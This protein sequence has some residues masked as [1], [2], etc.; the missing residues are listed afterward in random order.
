MQ[1]S[2]GG[3]SAQGD[4]AKDRR[5]QCEEK[6][7]HSHGNTEAHIPRRVPVDG[8]EAIL[9]FNS[10]RR[11]VAEKTDDK[12]AN[13]TAND[14]NRLRRCHTYHDRR[15]VRRMA[16]GTGMARRRGDEGRQDKATKEDPRAAGSEY[17]ATHR[18]NRI[19]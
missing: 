13:D 8:E 15:A 18:L 17:T 6:I 9:N 11:R 14:V 3:L 5:G 4:A 12:Q 10:G 7:N 16:D 19:N 1:T 2:V